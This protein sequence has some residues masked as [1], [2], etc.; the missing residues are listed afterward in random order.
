MHLP[1]LFLSHGSPMMAVEPGRTGAMLAQLGQSL[2][3]PEAILAVSPHWET[4]APQLASAAR[5]Q[6]IYDFGG[7]PQALYEIDYPAPGA[8]ALAQEIAHMLRDA[9]LI[10]QTNED[11][12]LDHGAWV[13]LHYLYPNAD[14]PVLQLSLQARQPPAYHFRIGRLLAPLAAKNILIASTG[15]FTHNLRELHRGEPDAGVAPYTQEFLDWFL[16]QMA[17]GDLEALLD[18]RARAPHAARAHPRDEHLL[19]LFLAMGA[20]DDWTRF[21]HF[22][23]GSTYHVLRMDSFAFGHA[24]ALLQNVA[25]PPTPDTASK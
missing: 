3:R 13:P 16:E 18:Y 10:A 22:D 14:I 15:S 4:A 24:A 5:P 20:A 12:G 11:W 1:S 17:A 21:R 7:F 9:G 19:P 8:P 6:M 25:A 23:T 2:P